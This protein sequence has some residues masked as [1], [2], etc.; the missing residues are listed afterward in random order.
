MRYV[1]T[2]WMS[3]NA[4]FNLWSHFKPK[5]ELFPELF[6]FCLFDIHIQSYN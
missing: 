1:K 3:Q 6:K 5:S 2:C 4:K